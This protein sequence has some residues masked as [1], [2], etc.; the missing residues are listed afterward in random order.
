MKP[1]RESKFAAEGAAL[2]RFLAELRTRL[3]GIRDDGQKALRFSLRLTLG[4]FGANSGCSA[5][6]HPGQTQPELIR[7]IPRRSNWDLNL[8]RSLAGADRFD[9][10]QNVILARIN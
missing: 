7:E 8:I 5:A 10:P 9:V 4:H 3:K 1:V 6:I 2:W